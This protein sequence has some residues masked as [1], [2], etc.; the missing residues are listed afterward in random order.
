MGYFTDSD[1]S[2][3]RLCKNPENP[4]PR[5]KLPNAMAHSAIPAQAGIQ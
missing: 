3:R 4:K 1:N 5:E 2:L